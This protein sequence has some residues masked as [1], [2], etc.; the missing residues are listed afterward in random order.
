MF[1]LIAVSAVIFCIILGMVAYYY[2]SNRPRKTASLEVQSI[3]E[4]TVGKSKE[5][6]TTILRPLVARNWKFVWIS[7]NRA[8]GG[9]DGSM[10]GT[11]DK[12]AD[13][14]IVGI[15]T[16]GVVKEVIWHKVELAQ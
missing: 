8:R 1:I 12:S 6:A 14:Y 2:V 9:A 4:S 16:G 3:V 5:E 15:G 11:L 7:P 10:D 13:V